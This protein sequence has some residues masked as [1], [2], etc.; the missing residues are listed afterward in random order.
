MDERRWKDLAAEQALRISELEKLTAEWQEAA[1]K[2]I[3]ECCGIGGPLNDNR[4]GYS[5][6]QMGPFFRIVE[7]VK[8]SYNSGEDRG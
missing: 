4:L 6:A 7:L 3:Q 5:R 8:V 1:D 2:V